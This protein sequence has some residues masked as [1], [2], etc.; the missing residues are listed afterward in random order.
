MSIESAMPSNHLIPCHPLLLLLSI[1]PRTRAF[2]SGL[3]LHIRWPKYWNFSLSISLSREYSGLIYFLSICQQCGRPGFDP[4]VGKIPWRRTLQPTP[5]L[6]PGKSHGERS[7]V[8][9]SLWVAKSQK[10]LSDFT[11]TFFSSTNIWKRQFCSAEGSQHSSWSN[12]HIHT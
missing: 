11:F 12:S 7:L 4:W 9:Y 8:G 10:W 3:A 1:C 5:V 2:S 6:L